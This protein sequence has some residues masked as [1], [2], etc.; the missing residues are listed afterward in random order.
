MNERESQS[1]ESRWETI[2]EVL[3]EGGGIHLFGLRTAQ[4]WLFSREVIDQT[5]FLVGES[6]IRHRSTVDLGDS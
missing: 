4:G 2:V 3:T 6:E 5:G 1:A